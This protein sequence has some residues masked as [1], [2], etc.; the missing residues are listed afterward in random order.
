MATVKTQAAWA[1]LLGSNEW[2]GLLDPL[3]LSLRKLILRCGD[4]CQATYDSF[5][6]DANSKFCGSSRYGMKSL[7]QQ[8][9]LPSASDYQIITFLYATSSIDVSDAFLI[10]ST[11]SE[12]WDRQSNWMGYIAVTT[13]QVSKANGRREVYVAWRGTIRTLEWADVF[14]ANLV[15]ATP[16]LGSGNGTD[17]D[18]EDVAEVMEGWLKIYT[19]NNPDSPFSKTSAK[20]QVL[21]KIKELMEQ[22]KDENLSL[23]FTGHSLGA[24]LA[25]LSAFDVVDN[26]VADHVQVAAF[27]FGL[28]MLGNKVF[29]DKLK[30]LQN[31]RLLHVRNVIDLIPHYPSTLLGYAY[32]GIEL[33]VDSRKSIYLKTSLNP[34]DWHNLQGI[35]HVVAGWNGSNG[36]FELKVKRC[37][38]LVNKSC[39][40][41]KDEYNVP[42][43]W[44]VEKNKGMVLDKNG[45]WV[46]AMPFEDAGF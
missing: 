18:G 42:G 45:D 34:G 6:S 38:A 28:P 27:V 44:W 11:S 29:C 15:P 16:L 31:L 32:V 26:G 13:D 21:T 30:A 39:D 10:N 4:F 20:T 19:S 43:S 33:L 22:Y 17:G 7:F 14:Q 36:E 35:L 1:E 25:A 41:L 24:A 37:L 3:D 2:E 9:C 23:I 46:S 40:F 8:V 12:A 5:I